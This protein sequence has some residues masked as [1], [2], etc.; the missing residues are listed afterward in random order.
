MFESEEDKLDKNFEEDDDTKQK[1]I[2]K[3]SIDNSLNFLIKYMKSKDK[4]VKNRS[5]PIEGLV[6]S[7]FL[8]Q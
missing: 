8:N 2:E 5:E 4:S 6:F 7:Q 3:Y 1:L